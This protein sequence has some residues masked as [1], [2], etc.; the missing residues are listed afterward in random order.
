MSARARRSPERRVAREIDDML[1]PGGDGDL[2]TVRR[3]W[4]GLAGLRG[5]DNQRE[6]R[7]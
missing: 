1:R 7:R 6:V 5:I 2:V 3:A 4:A